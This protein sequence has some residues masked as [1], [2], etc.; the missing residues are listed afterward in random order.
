MSNYCQC[1]DCQAEIRH[2]KDRVRDLENA[3]EQAKRDTQD[4]V[5]RLSRRLDA[6]RSDV[7]DL[8]AA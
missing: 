3:L 1:Y 4:E 5:E 2:L 7:S 6:I 8:Y